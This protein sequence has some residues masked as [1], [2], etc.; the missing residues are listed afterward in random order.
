MDGSIAN[1]VVSVNKEITSDC[2]DYLDKYSWTGW[3]CVFKP[4]GGLSAAQGN[5]PVHRQA[6][7]TNWL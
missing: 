2:S 6:V 4:P 1:S 5:A 7:A 3:G